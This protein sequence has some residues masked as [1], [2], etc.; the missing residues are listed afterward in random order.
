VAPVVWFA[1]PNSLSVGII[2]I[3]YTLQVKYQPFLPP[4]NDMLSD[5]QLTFTGARLVYVRALGTNS[6]SS[7]ET[8]LPSDSSAV[9]PHGC[10]VTSC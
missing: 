9:N 1:I 6:C 5:Q 2:F 7:F 8:L 3:S 10:F 4:N